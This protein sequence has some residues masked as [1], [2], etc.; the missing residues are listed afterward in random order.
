MISVDLR[1]EKTKYLQGLIHIFQELILS[2]KGPRRADWRSERDDRRLWKADFRPEV[3]EGQLKASEGKFE[4][5]E[6]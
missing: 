6:G 3:S 2:P 1:R 5:L 4:A